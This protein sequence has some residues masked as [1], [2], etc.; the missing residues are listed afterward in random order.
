MKGVVCDKMK[1]ISPKV[2]IT[3]F[4]TSVVEGE[5]GLILIDPGDDEVIKKLDGKRK[6]SGSLLE[7]Y[8][9]WEETGKPIKYVILINSQKEHI[10]NLETLARIRRSRIKDFVNYTIITHL[11]SPLVEGDLIK[12]NGDL[13]INLDGIEI[14]FLSTPGPS[15]TK[16]DLS[17]WLPEEE[18]LFVGDLLQ[19]QG[20]SYE[21]ANFLSPLPYFFYG[22]EYLLSLEKLLQ[23]PFNIVR[24]GYGHTL[25]SVRAKQWIEVTKTVITR[26]KE[27]VEE[28]LK[29]NINED[30]SRICEK[31]FDTITYERNF[32]REVALRRKYA[33]NY[34]D[35][36]D[37]ELFDC[38]GILYFIEKLKRKGDV[39]Q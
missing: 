30:K 24:T 9:L 33:L 3:Q 25:N 17:I 12:I 16:D 32:N 37:F 14:K 13:L 4:K 21:E 18:V 38:P 35:K 2:Y 15:K 31:V 34:R 7:A 26:I 22:D 39:A 6:L 8:E 20:E 10:F 1:K 27:I 36:S 29:K 23:I 19:P 28:V 11:N 5:R